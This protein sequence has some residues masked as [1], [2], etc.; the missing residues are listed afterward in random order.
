MPAACGAQHGRPGAHG[1]RLYYET[2]MTTTDARGIAQSKLG[3][4]VA[5][6]SSPGGGSTPE[7]LEECGALERAIAAFHLEAIRFRMFNVDRMLTRAAAS[8]AARQL[9]EDVRAALEAAGFHTRSH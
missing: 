5:V 1:P 6:I 8:P 4:L 7:L 3:E 2:V 9:F